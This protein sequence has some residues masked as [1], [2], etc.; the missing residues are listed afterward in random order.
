MLES[1]ERFPY[2]N[3]IALDKQ[4]ERNLNTIDIEGASSSTLKSPAVRNKWRARE[5]IIRKQQEL[6]QSL[7]IERGEATDFE[8]RRTIAM[9][10]YTKN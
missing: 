3:R 8:R 1:P 9:K 7:D 2:E 4:Y 5:V 10:Q 6:N